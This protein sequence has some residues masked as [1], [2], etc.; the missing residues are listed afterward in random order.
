MMAPRS[1]QILTATPSAPDPE[2]SSFVVEFA[3]IVPFCSS[4]TDTADLSVIC[5]G[6]K[7]MKLLLKYFCVLLYL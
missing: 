1:M 4:P 2:N 5:R 6:K 7:E 3:L